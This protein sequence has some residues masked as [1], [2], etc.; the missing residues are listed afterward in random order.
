MLR[1]KPKTSHSKLQV[2]VG[3]YTGLPATMV[4]PVAPVERIASGPMLLYAG[5][6]S[7]KGAYGK[8]PRT[9]SCEKE[10]KNMPHPARITDLP[11]PLTSQAI[12]TRGAKFL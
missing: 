7:K 11:L 5:P 3:A 10:S 9:T 6:G 12:L 2:V 8:C 1:S 4:P